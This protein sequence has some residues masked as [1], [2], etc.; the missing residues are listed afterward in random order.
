MRSKRTSG[1][2]PISV[3]PKVRLVKKTGV[4]QT[5]RISVVLTK[6]PSKIVKFGK[7]RLVITPYNEFEGTDVICKV[8]KPYI[9]RSRKTPKLVRFIGKIVG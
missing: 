4:K 5:N 9:A 8:S 3:S 7:N 6:S 2:R 1:H